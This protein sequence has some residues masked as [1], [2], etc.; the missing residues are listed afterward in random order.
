[1]DVIKIRKLAA[2]FDAMNTK[3]RGLESLFREA[4]IIISTLHSWRGSAIHLRQV[5]DSQISGMSK[6]LATAKWSFDLLAKR[7]A[8]LRMRKITTPTNAVNNFSYDESQMMES[9]PL[10][11]QQR[12]QLDYDCWVQRSFSIMSDIG[13]ERNSRNQQ[14]YILTWICDRKMGV[15]RKIL[16]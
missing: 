5:S 4:S 13:K 6:V 2:F 3:H 15:S 11:R 14:I 1:M 9:D 12:S 8:S 16:L 7:I 10:I